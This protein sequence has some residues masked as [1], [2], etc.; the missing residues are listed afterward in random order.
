[1]LNA[2][3]SWEKIDGNKGF[4][5]VMN[6]HSVLMANNKA[7][8]LSFNR[9]HL[10][11]LQGLNLLPLRYYWISLFDMAQS[12]AVLKVVLITIWFLSSIFVKTLW[13]PRID[14]SVSFEIQACKYIQHSGKGRYRLL[15]D[16]D[17]GFGINLNS[18]QQS[19]CRL[20]TGHNLLLYFAYYYQ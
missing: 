17:W 4:N 18:A 3:F 6:F 19:V 2:L 11:F 1:M 7:D 10:I 14:E 15:Q 12:L 8:Y 9:C 5:G 20:I 13:P 16:S